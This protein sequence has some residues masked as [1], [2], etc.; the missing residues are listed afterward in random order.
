ME[1]QRGWVGMTWGIKVR[2][3]AFV[4]IVTGALAL[5]SGANWVDFLS[6]GWSF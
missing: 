4:L 1:L 3:L 6:N 2:R 5:A